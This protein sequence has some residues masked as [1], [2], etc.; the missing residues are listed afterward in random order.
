M[1]FNEEIAEKKRSRALQKEQGVDRNTVPAIAVPK[2]IESSSESFSIGTGSI[3][4]GQSSE[5]DKV[6]KKIVI[7]GPTPPNETNEV[8]VFALVKKKTMFGANLGET[9]N[10][11]SPMV[12]K[13]E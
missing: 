7:E 13:R 10:S 8:K 12:Q 6:S 5:L 1:R 2:E 3:A 11:E 9:K 4:S